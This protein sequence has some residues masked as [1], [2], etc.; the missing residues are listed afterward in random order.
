MSDTM[1]R[2][3]LTQ[4]LGSG[5]V[6]IREIRKR[7]EVQ[8][9]GSNQL[10][11]AATSLGVERVEPKWA[12]PGSSSDRTWTAADVAKA[13]IDE[14]ERCLGIL[15]NNAARGREPL[16][17]HFIR[18]GKQSAEA[19]ELL[20]ASSLDDS[21]ARPVHAETGSGVQINS[22]KYAAMRREAVE[23]ARGG[24]NVRSPG[25]GVTPAQPPTPRRPM[26]AEETFARRRKDVE[27]W[28]G[29]QTE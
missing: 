5:P 6:S 19:I 18:T 8:G 16:A 4:Q 3:W 10:E 9:L 20:A 7:A 25:S 27:V 21:A 23:R 14:R 22:A 24:T 15:D 28:R 12:L 17:L 2:Q 29:R 11:A 13:T 26:T 1:I